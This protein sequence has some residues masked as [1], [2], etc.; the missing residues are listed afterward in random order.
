MTHPAHLPVI[1]GDQTWSTGIHLPHPVRT[2][3]PYCCGWGGE[4]GQKKT[5]SAVCR[6]IHVPYICNFSICSPSQHDPK[7]GKWHAP[8]MTRPSCTPKPA[9]RQAGPLNSQANYPPPP[10][11]HTHI[12]IT[13]IRVNLFIQLQALS[14]LGPRPTCRHLSTGT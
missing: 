7:L 14:H 6:Q 5:T 3:W 9:G 8:H 13:I 2:A 4:E 10:P 11:T 1:C 12:N